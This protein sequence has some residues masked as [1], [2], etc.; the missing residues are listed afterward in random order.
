MMLAATATTCAMGACD[1]SG[2]STAAT[3]TPTQL[4]I[5]GNYTIVKT[6]IENTCDGNLTPSTITGTVTHTAGASMFTLNDS[7]SLFPGTVQTNGTF[8]IAPQPT[9]PHLGAPVTTVFESGRFTA[10]GFD[11]QV[12]LDTN[13]PLGTPAF[14]VCRVS[15]T[16]RGVKQG[17]PNVIP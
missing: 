11:A 4:R 17:S 10:A 6:T 14:G 12:R 8:S 9:A 15:Q 1:G 7:F 13:G 5:G 3:P 2:G 16:W